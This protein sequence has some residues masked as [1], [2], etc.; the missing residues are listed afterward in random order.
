MTTEL[1]IRKV[2]DGPHRAVLWLDGVPCVAVGLDEIPPKIGDILEISGELWR[3]AA[4]TDR[5]L[6]E[7]EAL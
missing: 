7:R 2:G 1:D 6:L 3:V 4:H 5:C